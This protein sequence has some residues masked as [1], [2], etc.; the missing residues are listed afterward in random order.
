MPPPYPTP[1]EGAFAKKSTS[2][3]IIRCI[4][5]TV[6]LSKAESSDGLSG[7]PVMCRVEH[8]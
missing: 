3:S 8:C 5:L 6:R 1:S 4:F 7:A 2:A